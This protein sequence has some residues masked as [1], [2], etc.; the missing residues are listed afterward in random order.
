MG[1]AR[2]HDG[3]GLGVMRRDYKDRNTQFDLHRFFTIT[4]QSREY[5]ALRRQV[6]ADE[7]DE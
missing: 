5:L 7:A 1:L 4:P 2:N 6:S 3:T